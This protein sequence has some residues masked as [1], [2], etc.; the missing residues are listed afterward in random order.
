MGNMSDGRRVASGTFGSV[1][2]DEEQM[3]EC[4]GVQAKSKFNKEKVYIPGSMAVDTKTTS[5]ENTGSLKLYHVNDNLPQRLQQYHREGREPRF[6]VIDKVKDPDTRGIRRKVY[7]NVSF[8]ESIL[9]DWERGKISTRD[10][11]FTFTDYE[12]L[13]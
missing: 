5:E 12:L 1:W 7:Y 9:S 8:D 2:L 11:P 13:D 3:A 6:T 10:Y 4:Y